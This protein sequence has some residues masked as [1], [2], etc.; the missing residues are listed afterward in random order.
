MG[1]E[2]ANQHWDSKGCVVC[3]QFF[4]HSSDT[5]FM[6]FLLCSVIEEGRPVVKSDDI[7]VSASSGR[8]LNMLVD[9]LSVVMLGRLKDGK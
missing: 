4:H 5:C 7:F 1:L 8:C 6:L 9:I 3:L 2:M